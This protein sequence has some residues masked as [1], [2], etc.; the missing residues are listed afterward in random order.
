ML[1][2]SCVQEV[3]LIR[4]TTLR[5]F[6]LAILVYVMPEVLDAVKEFLKTCDVVGSKYDDDNGHC[7]HLIKNSLHTGFQICFFF[8]V[9]I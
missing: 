5:M 7:N 2:N 3:L 9:C 4:C 8:G 1:A 6:A